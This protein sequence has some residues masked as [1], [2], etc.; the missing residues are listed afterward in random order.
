MNG[1]VMMLVAQRDG[2]G[3]LAGMLCGA[4]CMIPAFLLAIFVIAGY[5][6][7]FVKAG[8]PGWAS[9]VPIYNGI[10]LLQ[11]AGRPVWWIFLFFI[12]AVNL[13]IAIIVCIDLARNFGKDTAFAI[14]LA[15]LPFI[16][17][18]ILGFG[19]AQYRPV[20]HT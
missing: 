16:F 20:A 7:V 2:S 14:G 18:M 4:V 13:V 9:L 1:E 8:Q 17:F 5:W 11:I 15:L 6:K 10:V 19:N 3:G 12:P